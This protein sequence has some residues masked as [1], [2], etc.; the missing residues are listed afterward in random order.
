MLDEV[1]LKLLQ[2]LASNSR[3]SL[4]ELSRDLGVAVSTVHTRIQK[5]IR[6]GVVRRFTIQPDYERLGYPITAVIL[7]VV[8]GGRIEEVAERLR[9][10]PNLIAVYDVTGD[11]DLVLIGKFRS[12]SELNA[13]I[14]RLNRMPAIRRTVTSVVLKVFKEDPVAPLNPSLS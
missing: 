6:E 12:M 13:F 4:R 2:L 11:Y 14:K 3:A 9:E 1:D 10:E 8:E 7:V 5:L